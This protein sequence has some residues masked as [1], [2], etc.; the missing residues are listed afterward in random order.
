MIDCPDPSTGEQRVI[1]SEKGNF[2]RTTSLL[3]FSVGETV[4]PLWVPQTREQQDAAILRMHSLDGQPYDLFA[5][6][7]EHVV[8][9]A[10]TGKSFSEQLVFAVVVAL[11]AAVIALAVA[12][13][14]LGYRTLVIGTNLGYA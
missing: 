2:V 7:C 10:V 13:S 8:N 14:S 6:N 4:S 5:A 1:H 12:K 9:W 3:E 11:G